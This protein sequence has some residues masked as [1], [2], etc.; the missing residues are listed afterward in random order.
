MLLRRWNFIK[1]KFEL[2]KVPDY[3]KVAVCSDLE[4]M[5]SKIDCAICGKP[6]TF[7]IAFSSLAVID[8]RGNG[9]AI[10]REYH[11]AEF[12]QRLKF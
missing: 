12:E 11:S 9:Y 4:H 6:I 8:Y 7:G 5:Y 1:R 10:C 3:R 2:F